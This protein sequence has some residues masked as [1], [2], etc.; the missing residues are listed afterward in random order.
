MASELASTSSGQADLEE[1]IENLK[2]VR[3][4]DEDT[5]GLDPPMTPSIGPFDVSTI[6]P[7]SKGIDHEQSPDEVS[8]MSNEEIK[9]H[10]D[11]SNS[12]APF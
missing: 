1:S 2:N 3:Y 5:G 10:S 4:T 9:T 8:E 6:E 12:S 7:F 11:Q